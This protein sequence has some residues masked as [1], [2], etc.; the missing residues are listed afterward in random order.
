MRLDKYLKVSRIFKRRTIAKEVSKNGR[1][2]I[3]DRVAKP[4]SEIKVDDILEISY[5]QKMIKV[6]VLQLSE[7]TKKENADSMYQIIEE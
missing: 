7:Y 6:R 3:N 1:V 2:L 4:G 5:G